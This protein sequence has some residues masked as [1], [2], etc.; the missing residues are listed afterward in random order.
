[1][2]EI[3]DIQKQAF[4]KN[5][6][7]TYKERIDSLRRCIALIEAHEGLLIETLNQDFIHRSKDEIKISEI[8]QT[9]RNL[10][11]TIKPFREL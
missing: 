1:M 3:L 4:S 5:G 8:D 9:I 11:F 7:P 10:L 2:K 6:P